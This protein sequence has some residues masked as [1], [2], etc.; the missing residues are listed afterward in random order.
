MAE[1]EMT[2]EP[3]ESEENAPVPGWSGGVYLD[4]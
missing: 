1:K 4:Y 3:V 2:I